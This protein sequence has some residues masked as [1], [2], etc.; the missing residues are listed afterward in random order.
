[1]RKMILVV[2]AFL[3]SVSFVF[4]DQWEF[5]GAVMNGY[6]VATNDGA[7]GVNV[8]GLKNLYAVGVDPDGRVWAGAYYSRLLEG[9]AGLPD[10]DRYPDLWY[11]INGTDTVEIW[12]K[13]IFVWD[14]VDDSIDTVRFLTFAGGGQDTLVTHRGMARSYDGNMI[15]ASDV[16]IWKVNY[17][18]YEVIA[19]W[20]FPASSQPLQQIACDENG[21]VYATGLW[22]GVV[23]VLDPD[24]LSEYTQATTTAPSTRGGTVSSDGMHVY[25][26]TGMTTAGVIDYYSADGPDGTY[27]AVDTV[28]EEVIASGCA[29][30]DP[31][32]YLW[33]MACVDNQSKTWSFDPDNN[34]SVVDSTSFAYPGAADTTSGGYS[35]PE[36]VRCPRE[37]AYNVAGDKMYIAEYYGYTIKEY[38]YTTVSVDQEVFQ[39]EAFK[40]SQNYP[41]PFNPTTSIPFE[42]VADGFVKLTVYDITGRT[43]A[44][45]I[46]QPMTSGYHVAEFNGS[47]MASGFYLY[48]LVVDGHK[49]VRKMMLIE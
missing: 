15:V 40:L 37:Y 23:Y 26:T 47:D 38:T 34:F 45:L 1:M 30:W 33:M 41:N 3:I 7:A 4:A 18:T 2:L 32:G 36:F 10:L 6:S 17:Q 14:P 43:V 22:G 48:E 49:D 21:Y 46:N 12:N 24:D 20:D 25:A 35:L 44:S 13:P 8:P 39:P 27:A 19:S 28:A 42:L 31:A 11:E 5:T 16:K 9:T 29:A